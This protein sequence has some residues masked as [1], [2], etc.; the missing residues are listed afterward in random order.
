MNTYFKSATVT[1]SLQQLSN[2]KNHNNQYS[3]NLVYT[4]PVGK[5]AQ[6]QLNYNPSFQNNNADQETFNYDNGSSKY[7]LLD[8][9]L[10]NK[11]NNTYN[12][13]NGGIT[14]RLG[15]KDNMISA[16][17]SYQYGELKSNQVFPQA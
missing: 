8:T 2:Q 14:Y 13:Q 10:S 4:E 16:G 15:D 5:K 17:V 3:F 7:S 1:D 12:T 6:I 9:S 11:F